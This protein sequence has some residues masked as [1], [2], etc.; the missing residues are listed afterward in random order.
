MAANIRSI[1]RRRGLSLNHLAD[2]AGV[3]QRQ[4]YAFLAGDVD[5]TLG[6]LECVASALEVD[7]LDLTIP[8]ED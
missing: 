8:T 4:L 2:F 7:V 3:S 5:V 1:A 6:W